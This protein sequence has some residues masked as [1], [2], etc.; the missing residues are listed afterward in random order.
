M[1]LLEGKSQLGIVPLA[2]W[3]TVAY[4]N[5]HAIV[6]F[7][8]RQRSPRTYFLSEWMSHG[9][10]HSVI[11]TS[12]GLGRF[13]NPWAI[14]ATI[15]QG[16]YCGHGTRILCRRTVKVGHK[17][18]LGPSKMNDF[19]SKSQQNPSEYPENK[20]G[21]D[22]GSSL[23]RNKAVCNLVSQEV[24]VERRSISDESRHATCISSRTQRC[25]FRSLFASVSQT[26]P[27]IQ[28]FS[29]NSFLSRYLIASS[30]VVR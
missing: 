13:I 26:R 3:L 6:S 28:A 20:N 29:L 12:L 22:Q 19:C 21:K 4:I 11:G 18:L 1:I 5:P 23:H 8:I 27:E 15:K 16:S 9:D 2:A 25:N 24:F 7:R 14:S 10:V 30:K 17:G